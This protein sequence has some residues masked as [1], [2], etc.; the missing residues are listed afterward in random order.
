MADT[1][2]GPPSLPQ[3]HCHLSQWAHW[4]PPQGFLLSINNEY[5]YIVDIL[6]HK[7]DWSGDLCF[8][9]LGYSWHGQATR[10]RSV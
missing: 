7:T 10:L 2:W 3:G 4:K 1:L 5:R 9:P 8:W 6:C